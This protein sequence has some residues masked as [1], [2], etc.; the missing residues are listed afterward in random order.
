MLPALLA[1][2]A[3]AAAC[4][5]ACH[6]QPT[7]RARTA[8]ADPLAARA[9]AGD[10]YVADRARAQAR[11]WRASRPADAAALDALA[12]QPQAAWMGDWNTDVRSDV[13]GV[14]AAARG[15]TAVLVAYDIPLRDCGGYSAGGAG[16]AAVYLRWI[17]AFAAGL[18]QA[19]AAVVLE[20]DAVAGWDCLN[21][22]QR[23]ERA[24]LLRSAI[25]VLRAD[26]RAAV[27]LDAGN[28]TWHAPAAI[29]GR[30]RQAGVAGARGFALNVSNFR[31][32][33]ESVA[34]GHAI[35]SALGRP[36]PFVVDTSRN[37]AG[38]A[39]G[40]A[41]CNPPGRA[42]GRPPTTATG[43]PLVDAFLWVKTPGE[44]DG[45]CNGGPAAG[46]WWPDYAVACSGAGQ[47]PRSHGRRP[48]VR[49]AR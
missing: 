16:S 14:V 42:L 30:L 8:A 3:L 45:T 47:T 37:G 24:A 33:A 11:R 34:Y 40:D 39:P 2:A 27:Y 38:P 7:V 5:G 17:S 43:D 44:S 49:G 26:R 22:A 10:P 12:A 18:G 19:P 31:T 25:A 21:V 6:A 35:S 20:P 23:R 4:P 32:T 15:A 48:R 46:E 41:W 9:L 28:S 36:T 29:A 13:A 1:A